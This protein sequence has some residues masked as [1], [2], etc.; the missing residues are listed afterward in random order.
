LKLD[1]SARV[2]TNDE[3]GDYLIWRLYPSHKVFLDGRSDF[4]GNAFEKKYQDVVNVRYGWDVILDEFGVDTVLMPVDAALAGALKE[5]SRWRVVYDDGIAVAFQHAP[6][7]TRREAGPV[8]ATVKEQLKDRN[9][10]ILTAPA[11]RDGRTGR[12]GI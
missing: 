5:S 6:P 8:V 4:Y 9:N 7:P 2:F 11:V 1:P 12:T 10:E 3:W